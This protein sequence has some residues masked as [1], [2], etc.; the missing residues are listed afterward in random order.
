MKTENKIIIYN[1][2]EHIECKICKKNFTQLTSHL[3][4]HNISVKKYLEKY[5]DAI[6]TGSI[7]RLKMSSKKKKNPVKSGAKWIEKIRWRSLLN[8]NRIKQIKNARLVGKIKKV[9]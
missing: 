6:L 4:I 5:P 8:E 3:R 1:I 2:P 9:G 7:T